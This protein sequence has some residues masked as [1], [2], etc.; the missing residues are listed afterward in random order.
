MQWAVANLNGNVFALGDGLYGRKR[1]PSH[2]EKL[3]FLPTCSTPDLGSDLGKA[4]LPRD[5]V[6]VEMAQSMQSSWNRA[7]SRVGMKIYFE[8][9][10]RVNLIGVNQKATCQV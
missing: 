3:S 6:D 4:P 2:I 5:R 8:S 9:P 7:V 1:M 10:G